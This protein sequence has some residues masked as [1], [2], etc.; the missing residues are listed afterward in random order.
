MGFCGE[1]KCIMGPY[2]NE[3]IRIRIQIGNEIPHI[4]GMWD[5]CAEQITSSHLKC[6]KVLP[7][8]VA[9]IFKKKVSLRIWG[10]APKS[11]SMLFFKYLNFRAKI[12]LID[13]PNWRWMGHRW[14]GRMK[15]RK[16]QFVPHCLLAKTNWVHICLVR[17]DSKHHFQQFGPERKMRL[18]K[19]SEGGRRLTEGRVFNFF[20][21][22]WLFY[23]QDFGFKTN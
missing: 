23:R 5:F 6:A 13:L 2:F 3:M 1:P 10:F 20:F 9:K 8:H 22:S 17:W 14:Q 16:N 4:A 7:D 18:F 11:Y 21:E 15:L 19:L 12:V